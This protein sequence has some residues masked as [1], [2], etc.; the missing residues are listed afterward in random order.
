[1]S[2]ELHP[3][4]GGLPGPLAAFP[5]GGHAGGAEPDAAT[6][7]QETAAVQGSLSQNREAVEA[8][9]EEANQALANTSLSVRFSV[10]GDT[11]RIVVRLT[12]QGTGKVVRQ[13]P[14]EDQLAIE[15]RLRELVGVFFSSQA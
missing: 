3:V 8:A 15:A 11:N 6:S 9:I 4:G 2:Q 5:S 13:I 10:E 14:S 7:E 12:D 1:M